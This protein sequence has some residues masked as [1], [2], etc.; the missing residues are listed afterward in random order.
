VVLGRACRE[1]ADCNEPVS[2]GLGA[3]LARALGVIVI[4][5]EDFKLNSS[6]FRA[7]PGTRLSP[8]RGP[9]ELH[10]SW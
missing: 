2:S 7:Q 4:C 8:E 3:A 1:P 9:L 5:D 10:E 6:S